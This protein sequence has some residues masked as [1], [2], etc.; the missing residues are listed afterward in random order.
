MFGDDD[1]IHDYDETCDI[2]RGIGCVGECLDED[3]YWPAW[4][5]DEYEEYGIDYDRCDCDEC[6]DDL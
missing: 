6:R 3:L 2:C 4:G 1:L 5:P